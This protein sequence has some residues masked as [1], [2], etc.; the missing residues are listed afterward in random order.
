MFYF[1]LNMQEL[2]VLCVSLSWLYHR[3]VLREYEHYISKIGASHRCPQTQNCDVLERGCNNIRYTSVVRQHEAL[4]TAGQAVRGQGA[5][6]GNIISLENGFAI[7]RIL[8][9]DRTFCMYQPIV[10]YRTTVVSMV[11]QSR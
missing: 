10:L 2:F 3:T 4:N 6:K 1:S 5:L 7:G 9:V 11:T 8:F